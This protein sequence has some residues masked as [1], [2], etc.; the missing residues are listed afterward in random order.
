MNSL[1]IHIIEK[2]SKDAST[3]FQALQYALK[4]FK[5]EHPDITSAALRQDNVMQPQ[6]GHAFG[7]PSDGFNKRALKSM[8]S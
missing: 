1:N 4:A 7:M 8:S 6:C 5:P 2:C 3:V